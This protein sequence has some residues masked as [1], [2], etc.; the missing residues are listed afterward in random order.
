MLVRWANMGA[1]HF[2]QAEES[3]SVSKQ[4]QETFQ[5]SSKFFKIDQSFVTA[6]PCTTLIGSGNIGIVSQKIS[7]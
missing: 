1:S 5:K 2:R 7:D 4:S 3:V 6:A